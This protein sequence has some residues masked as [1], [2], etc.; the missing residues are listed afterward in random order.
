MIRL[1][2]GMVIGGLIVAYF[3]TVGSEVRAVTNSTAREIQ[4]ATEPTLIE[5]LEKDVIDE[6]RK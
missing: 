1:A 2:I 5:R 4:S 6:L 3:P